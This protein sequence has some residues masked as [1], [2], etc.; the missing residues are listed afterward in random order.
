MP[1]DLNPAKIGRYEVKGRLGQ[2]AMGEVFRAHD[3]VLN[4]EV[5]IKRISAGLDA[6][7][8]VR[9]RFQREA[10]SA[11]N[12]SHPN[13]ITVYELGIE[14]E[15]FFMAMELL[16]GVDL[17]HVL[18]Q[19]QMTLEE[20]LDVTEQICEGLAFAHS[21]GVVHRDLKPANIHILPG[22]KVKIMDFGLARMSGSD[23]TSTGTVMG[24]PHYMSPEQVRGTRADTRSD[25]FSLGCVLYEL[26]AGRK[27]FDA[28][29]M[30]AVL[31]KVLQEEPPPV[32]DLAPGLPPVLA[33]VVEKALAKDPMDRFQ[34]AGE[35]LASIRRARQATAAGRG[36]ERVPDLERT[37]AAP[38]AR[39]P[40]KTGGRATA[41]RSGSRPPA[42]GGSRRT[43]VIG[44]VVA[45]LAVAGGSW[46]LRAFVLGRPSATPPPEVANLAAAVA[47]TQ[48]E[49]AQRKLDAGDYA[50]AVRQ[51]ERALKLFPA[52]AEARAVA[53]EAEAGLARV[54]AALLALRQAAGGS[55]SAAAAFELMKI[56]PRH[57]DAEVAAAAAG[58]AFRP[59]AEE[60]RRLAAE[61]RVAAGASRGPAYTDG[62]ALE[63]EGEQSLRTGQA[64]SAA[65][66]F[67]EARIRFQRAGRPSR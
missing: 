37:L 63:K 26:L 50:E 67:L 7:D 17:K 39:R 42:S 3:P 65:Q 34:S 2:G 43:L 54:E 33:Q 25:V 15:Q 55:A 51:A 13:I 31:F 66:S 32:L 46:A 45:L 27:P 22:G 6:D 23:M 56:A 28:E 44:L 47:D 41:S 52:N 5:A 57:P 29:S 60:A 9:R 62:V 36:H 30:H 18:A 35:M 40:S 48:V 20:R 58:T 8:M 59:R 10:Q 4:R 53:G 61:A 14:A 64:V 12:L 11:A 16:N 38:D 21:H 49:L 24:T 19:R 1:A